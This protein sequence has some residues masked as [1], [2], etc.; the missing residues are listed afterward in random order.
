MAKVTIEMVD[1]DE[2]MIFRMTGDPIPEDGTASVAQ[3]LG[4]AVAA[5]VKAQ[6]H[7]AVIGF[8]TERVSDVSRN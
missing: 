4:L 8:V 5:T 1:D 7:D 3:A 2:G 6:I